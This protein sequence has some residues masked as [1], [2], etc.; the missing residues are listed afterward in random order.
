VSRRLINLLGFLG[1][2]GLLGYAVYA[3]IV[4]SLEPC[5]LCWFQRVGVAL[6]GIVFLIAMLHHPKRWGVHVY[7][8]LTGLAA[9]GTVGVAARHVYVQHM[10]PG[11]LPSCGA[12][13]EYLIRITPFS[14]LTQLFTKILTESGECA[15]I[16]WQFLG[17]SMPEWV[18]ISALLLGVLGVVGNLLGG[19]ERL[20]PL[21]AAIR[22]GQRT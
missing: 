11:S 12:P 3:Q 16:N 22:E 20:D 9:L 6:L 1:C 18:L 10:P 5:P 8:A 14:K 19:P 4:L 2:V 13:L 21:D 17:L 7:V 15:T